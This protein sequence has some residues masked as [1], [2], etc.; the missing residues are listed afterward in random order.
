MDSYYADLRAH[1]YEKATHSLEHNK[2]IKKNRNALLYNLE[3]GRL[4]R[5]K[6]DPVNS[7]IF[8]NHADNM[9]EANQKSLK[10]ITLSNLLNPM[11]EDYRGEDFEQFMMH[12]YKALNYA[13]LGQPDDAVVEA[14]RITLSTNAQADKFKN[15][16][17]V[18]ARMHLRS[19]CR[20]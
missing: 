7:N 18:T 17:N 4:Y 2:L 1:D 3:M 14:R 16:E 10:D 13:A 11:Y 19:T 6:N 20:G 5:L 8:F 9:M 15:T 12:Y